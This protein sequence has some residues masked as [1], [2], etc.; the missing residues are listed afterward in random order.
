MKIF[1]V[2]FLVIQIF[3]LVCGITAEYLRYRDIDVKLISKYDEFFQSQMEEVIQNFEQKITK[4]VVV[5]L[6]NIT[7]SIEESFDQMLQVISSMK[8]IT[9]KDNQII[10]TLIKDISDEN[11]R[12]TVHKDI[13]QMREKMKTILFNMSS[14]NEIVEINNDVKNKVIQDIRNDLLYLVNVFN[15]HSTNFKKYPLLAMQ[16]LFPLTPIVTAHHYIAAVL[17]PELT[18]KSTIECTLKRVLE[19]YKPLVIV[20]R[21]SK[22]KIV[23]TKLPSRKYGE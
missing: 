17:T 7:E 18:N 16:I 13:V 2:L 8:N 1:R 20:D 4:N 22:I 23:Q 12:S 9:S 10:E 19:E 21:L 3:L 11:E 5:G 15:N 6:E 14:L